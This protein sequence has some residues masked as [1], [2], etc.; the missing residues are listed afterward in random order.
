[1]YVFENLPDG[2]ASLSSI[3]DQDYEI[4]PSRMITLD[5]YLIDNKVGNVNFVKMDVEGAELM[6]LKG[7]GR[8]FKQDVPPI[9]VIEMAL[10]TSIGFDYHPNDLIEF[11]GGQREYDF[12]EID[13]IRF[14]LKK[15]SGFKVEEIGANVLCVPKNQYRERLSRLKFSEEN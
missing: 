11:I 5:S 7:A 4:A 6:M 9:W 10:A 8:L 1:M 12:Y 2:R 15:I 14:L 3:A 13:E